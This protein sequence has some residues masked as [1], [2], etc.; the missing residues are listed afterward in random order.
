MDKDMIR[1]EI[2]GA[3]KVDNAVNKVSAEVRLK[4]CK[5]MLEKAKK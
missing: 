1:Y 4:A 3:E 5:E 2:N